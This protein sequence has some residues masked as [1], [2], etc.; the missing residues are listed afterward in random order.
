MHA[1]KRVAEE[2]TREREDDQRAHRGDRLTITAG[3]KATG[4][5]WV[6]AK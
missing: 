5:E 4:I 2:S 6:L 3:A 1:V